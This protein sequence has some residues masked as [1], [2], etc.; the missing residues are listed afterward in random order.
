M[1]EDKTHKF[2]KTDVIVKRIIELALVMF[3]FFAAYHQPPL[4]NA[5]DIQTV[6]ILQGLL[7]ASFV[8]FALVAF[9]AVLK[10]WESVISWLIV[11][12]GKY[13]SFRPWFVLPAVLISILYPLLNLPRW[14]IEVTL[15]VFITLY[16]VVVLPA[17]LL[18]LIRDDRRFEKMVLSK[19]ITRNMLVQNPQ[20]AIEHAF[21]YFE[22]H[23]RK[24]V[25]NSTK[26]YAGNLISAAFEGKNS[27]LKYIS[28]GRDQ[29]A[30]LHSLISGAYSLFRNPR[31]HRIVDDDP[32]SAQTLV[33]L[34]E[35][36]M[37]FVDE[38]ENRDAA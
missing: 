6:K 37:R 29:T 16:L 2:W 26:L 7:S 27:Q 36:L 28:D 31:H 1:K 13:P 12:F 33:S 35:M 23:L 5:L 34:I 21:T 38:C 9:D 20:A 10:I 15:V 11:F 19:S 4:S 25:P 14:N 8:V 18:S 30:H 22:D 17:A 3:A 32:T 24:R